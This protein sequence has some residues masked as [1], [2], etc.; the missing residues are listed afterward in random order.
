[1]PKIAPAYRDTSAPSY[2]EVIK[3]DPR[4]APALF[5]AYSE[6]AIDVPGVPRS[7]YT[8]PEFAQAELERMWP[9]VWQVACREEQ[10][11]ET[12]DLV[13]YHSP[14]A[15]LLI[16][17]SGPDEIKAFYNS[18]LHRGMQLCAHDTSVQ[19]LTCPFHGFAWNLDGSLAH[20][21]ARWDFPQLEEAKFNLPEARTG[22]WGGF[23]F[24]NRDPDAAPLEDYLANLPEHFA[25]WPRESVYLAQMIHKTMNAN[26]KTCI[27]GFIESFHLAGIHSQALP[28][29]GDASTQYDV[30][31]GNETIS[32]FLEPVGVQSDQ[33]P[34]RLNEQEILEASLATVFGGSEFPQLPKDMRARTFLA[35][36]T[37]QAMSAA[38]GRDYS[39][40]SDTEAA[41]AMQYSVF[42]NFVLFR[43]LT[44][45]Y[46]Y[47]FTPVRD[48]P[49]QAVFD[50][51][52][53]KPKPQD[54]SPVPETEHVDL[55]PGDSFAACGALPPW[56]GQIYDQDSVG[57][58]MCQAGLRDGGTAGVMFSAYQEVRIRH[59]HQTLARYL[60]MPPL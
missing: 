4:P 15:S 34:R 6:A 22:R 12:G 14:G 58:A 32:R 13:V 5:T 8:S 19:K 24:I 51:M 31:P 33:Y 53:F 55:G 36:A 9:R 41:D 47:R 11:P 3:H 39:T 16:V 48:N 46:A 40:L 56:L 2:Q 49:N 52:I 23:V 30:W 45:P 29:G 50:F 27:E 1:M 26:W 37:R 20:V 18:C 60:A 43:S 10:I 25:D 35:T 57:L 59:L 17:R 7:Q 44:Y 42:P 38:D 54:G 21:P 28:F